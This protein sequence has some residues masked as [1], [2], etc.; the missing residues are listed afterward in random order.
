MYT[1]KNK[2]L[3]LIL[4]ISTYCNAKCPQCSRTDS[5]SGG[6]KREDWVPLVHWSLPE[7]QLAYPKEQLKD[8]FYIQLCPTWGDAMM[9]PE[10]YEIT[11]YFLENMKSGSGFE[12]VTNGSMR[13]EDFWFNFS[14]LG[15]IAKARNMRFTVMFDVDGITQEM[16]SHYRRNTNLQKVLNN[17]KAFS[18]YPVNITRTQSVIFKHNQDYTAEI[19]KLAHE[20]GSQDHSFVKSSRFELDKDGN[21]MPWEFK[22]ENNE[23]EYYEWADKPFN[24]PY[25]ALIQD[26]GIIQEKVACKWSINNTLN[27]NFDGQVWPCCYFGSAD[28]SAPSTNGRFNNREIIKEYNL[29]RLHYNVKFTPLRD[30]VKSY[31]Y[32]NSLPKTIDSEPIR[33]CLRQCSTQIRPADKLEI[34]SK[35]GIGNDTVA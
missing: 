15:I 23:T 19:K 2:D 1:W 11:K 31:W 6:L 12:I 21:Y 27:I 17:M 9:N 26:M 35:K 3:K 7:I 33:Q 25:M 13:D 10:I 22:N 30:I 18:S 16:H 20:Y 28:H 4:D 24:E 34:R 5:K 14:A 8:V 32:T 29:K